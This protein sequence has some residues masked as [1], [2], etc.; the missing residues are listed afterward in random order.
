MLHNHSANPVEKNFLVRIELE[1]KIYH[2]ENRQ[3]IFEQLIYYKHENQKPIK[4]YRKNHQSEK[5]EQRK[6]R[7]RN[8]QTY[9]QK[10]GREIDSKFKLTK[11]LRYRTRNAFDVL[12]KTTKLLN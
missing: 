3:K 5:R 12:E 9:Y 10:N 11:N 6:K 8:H 4:I 7:R 1:E 2:S